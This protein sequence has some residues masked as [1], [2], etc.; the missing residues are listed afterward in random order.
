MLGKSHRSFKD[1]SVRRMLC[2]ENEQHA[3]KQVKAMETCF[4][5]TQ[6]SVNGDALKT[7]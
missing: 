4:D 3:L 1:N 5:R 2:L 6:S 7:G